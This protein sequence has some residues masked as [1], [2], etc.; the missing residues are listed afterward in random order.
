[1]QWTWPTEA[2]WQLDL[3]AQ[4]PEEETVAIS[5]IEFAVPYDDPRI[6]QTAEHL[7]ISSP[8]WFDPDGLCQVSVNIDTLTRI[9]YVSL[10]RPSNSPLAG[11]GQ[12]C[13]IKGGNSGVV[14]DDLNPRLASLEIRHQYD[15]STQ[16]LRLA[17]LPAEEVSLRV[18]T[19][20]GQVVH[21]QALDREQETI[22]LHLPLAQKGMYH[23]IL[24][25]RS[26]RKQ[27]IKFIV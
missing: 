21:S 10:S 16:L 4:S 12:V 6:S 27:T 24:I 13:R 22:K 26:G 17:N 23:L 14:L 2:V 25:S 8:Y 20:N 3:Y 18:I 5:L 15:P 11:D 19:V 7:S 1:F 9:V